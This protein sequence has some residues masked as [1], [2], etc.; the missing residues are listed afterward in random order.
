[1]KRKGF[2]LIEVLVVV[3]TLPVLVMILDRV[4]VDLAGDLPRSIDVIEDNGTLLHVLP[5]LEQDIG[6]A[7][8][9]P[10][11]YRQQQQDEQHLIIRQSGSVIV[12]EAEDGRII[13]KIWTAPLT[14]EENRT[15]PGERSWI[16]PRS[17]VHWSLLQTDT[18]SPYAVAVHTG[19]IHRHSKKEKM[20]N[21]YVYFLGAD[22][23]GGVIYE[24]H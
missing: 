22:R 20:N 1:M 13:R 16:T 21:T 24:T 17:Q 3:M 6:R 4:F 11:S 7:V 8:D 2:S 14:T 18:A 9:L 10:Q 15:E 12:Y 19:V 23:P 5:A